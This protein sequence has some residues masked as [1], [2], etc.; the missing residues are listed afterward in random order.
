MKI[1]ASLN[2]IVSYKLYK[3]CDYTVTF[4]G[5]CF[6]EKR[7]ILLFHFRIRQF[8][9]VHN[10]TEKNVALFSGLYY[11]GPRKLIEEQDFFLRGYCCK[12]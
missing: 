10:W 8:G 12:I 7:T 3:L 11:S 2:F 1:E 4:F 9:I 6:L 5:Y